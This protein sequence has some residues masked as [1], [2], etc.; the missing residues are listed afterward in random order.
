M[1][2][3]TFIFSFFYQGEWKKAR[4]YR[5]NKHV[6]DTPQLPFICLFHLVK[7]LN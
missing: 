5:P 4:F 7:A 3:N 2:Q 6:K 1:A